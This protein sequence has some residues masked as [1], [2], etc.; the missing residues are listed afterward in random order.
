MRRKHEIRTERSEHECQWRLPSCLPD[1]LALI[2]CDMELY[3]CVQNSFDAGRQRRVGS[4]G[5]A[6]R[7][8]YVVRGLS[9][10]GRKDTGQAAASAECGA[11]ISKCSLRAAEA[12]V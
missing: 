5:L 6:A 7:F 3:V 12:P 4:H 9:E 1:A 2:C 11:R 10:R 8:V